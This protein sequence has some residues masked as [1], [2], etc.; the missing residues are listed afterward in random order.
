MTHIN[1]PSFV[2]GGKLYS[3][4]YRDEVVV[5]EASPGP[6]YHVDEKIN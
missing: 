3:F 2:D 1:L 6:I 4:G 5:K